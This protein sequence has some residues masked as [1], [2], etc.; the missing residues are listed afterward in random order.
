M[1][2]FFK[3]VVALVEIFYEIFLEI[4]SYDHAIS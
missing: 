2:F 3:L 4:L 1:S